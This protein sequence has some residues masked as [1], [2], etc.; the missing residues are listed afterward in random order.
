MSSR[1][2]G[3]ILM[4]KQITKIALIATT[5]VGSLTLASSNAYAQNPQVQVYLNTI[6]QNLALTESNL[7]SICDL[8]RA[9]GKLDNGISCIG[10]KGN[11]CT[12]T[13]V[14][15]AALQDLI[16]QGSLSRQDSMET[17]EQIMK[18]RDKAKCAG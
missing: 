18:L 10:A 15:F 8:S 11:A 9:F 3:D 5:F 12:M 6:Q 14:Y 13:I 2:F 4:R 7:D 1:P 16:N 17:R